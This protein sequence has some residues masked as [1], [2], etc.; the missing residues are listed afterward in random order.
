[1]CSLCLSGKIYKMEIQ[2]LQIIKALHI[3]FVVTWFSGLFYIVRLFIY[4]TEAEKKEQPA[5]DILQTQYKT[6]ETR[7]WYI[8]TWPSMIFVLFTGGWLLFSKFGLITEAFMQLK[9]AFVFSLV[10][11]HFYCQ[12]IYNQ[13]QNDEVRFSSFI[14]RLFNEI[15][16]LLLFAIVFIIILRDEFGFLWGLGGLLVFG[17][18]LF[19][20]AKLYKGSREKKEEN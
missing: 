2:T 12:R 6:M 11:Y 14:L 1:L 5:K 4:H 3:I 17:L 16:T 10:L 19:I 15:A 18:L 7:L 13:L 20:A 9:L 8:I